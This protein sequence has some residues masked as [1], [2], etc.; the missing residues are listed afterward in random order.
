MVVI[1]VC[2]NVELVDGFDGST[3]AA[4]AFALT[5]LL[6]NLSFRASSL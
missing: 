2:T 5:G 4:A 6:P 3:D 1:R